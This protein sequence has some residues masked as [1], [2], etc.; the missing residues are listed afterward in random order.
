MSV[1]VS[2]GF[3]VLGEGGRGG[4]EGEKGWGGEGMGGEGR[5]GWMSMGIGELEGP[6]DVWFNS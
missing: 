5:G 6:I 3:W 2:L 1:G 4:R